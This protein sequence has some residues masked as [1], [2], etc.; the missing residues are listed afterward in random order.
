MSTSLRKKNKRQLEHKQQKVIRERANLIKINTSIPKK[1]S[2]PY[3][4]KNTNYR[5]TPIYPSVTTVGAI[6]TNKQESPKYTGEYIT[7][8]A[9][10]HK[11]NLVPVSKGIDPRDYATM[12]RN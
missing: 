7:G 12:R 4:N 8:I 3:E 10:M 2:T 5:E 1:E 6:S 11:S 9:T